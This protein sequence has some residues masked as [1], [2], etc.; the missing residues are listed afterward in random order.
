MKKTLMGLIA[1]AV[2]VSATAQEAGVIVSK[3]E[4]GKVIQVVAHPAG[5]QCVEKKSDTSTQVGAGAVGAGLGAAAGGL[6]F[7]KKGAMI[8]GL[9]GGG[10]GVLMAG[11]DKVCTQ[12]PANYD[13]FVEFANKSEVMVNTREPKVV[14]QAVV[15]LFYGNGTY[16]LR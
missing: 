12:M 5:Q 2:M 6:L 8:G 11:T 14:G 16:G 13:V 3:K 9:A 15:V 1:C 7:G 10:T 4:A